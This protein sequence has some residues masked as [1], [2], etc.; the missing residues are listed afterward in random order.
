[1]DSLTNSNFKTV[2]EK[3]YDNPQCFSYV[4]FEED[5]KRFQSVSRLLCRYTNTYENARLML[6]HIIILHNT[7]GKFAVYGL[8]FKVP[9]EKWETLKTFLNFLQL[10]PQ[11]HPSFDINDDEDILGL[12]RAL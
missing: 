8:F 7:F 6:N 1:M 2:A 3:Y 12:L 11:S 9:H 10:I 5:I 4:E